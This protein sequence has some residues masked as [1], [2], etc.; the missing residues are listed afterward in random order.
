MVKKGR[1]KPRCRISPPRFSEDDAIP[2]ADL[3][4]I[5]DGVLV[6]SE[7]GDI[8]GERRFLWYTLGKGMEASSCGSNQR[9]FDRDM[10]PTPTDFS[11]HQVNYSAT[12]Y[13]KPWRTGTKSQSLP[14]ATGQTKN[15]GKGGKKH[16]L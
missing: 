7:G 3:T 12:K 6:S 2:D 16:S 14:P 10:E 5:N 1:K 15:K 13:I 9:R 11:K 4:L 8:D